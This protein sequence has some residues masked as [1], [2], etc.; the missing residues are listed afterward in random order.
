MTGV[1][2]PMPEGA[3]AAC[4]MVSITC[5]MSDTISTRDG[6]R[7]LGT[8]KPM[9]AI[10]AYARSDTELITAHLAD[11]RTI[12]VPLAWSW[13]LSEARPE[14][15]ARYEIAWNWVEWAAGAAFVRGRLR[16]TARRHRLGQ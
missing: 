12:S 1:G 2:Q 10:G 5:R 8:E 14:Q 7:M 15:R 6:S 13:R 4:R 3:C 9:A 11:G 16:V